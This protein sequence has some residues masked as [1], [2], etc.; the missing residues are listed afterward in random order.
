MPSSEPLYPALTRALE[1]LSQDCQGSSVS[2]DYL[3]I[4]KIKKTKLNKNLM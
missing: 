3:A 4:A 2:I 1:A